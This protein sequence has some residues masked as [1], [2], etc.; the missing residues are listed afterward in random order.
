MTIRIGIM[1]RRGWEISL[2]KV[3]LAGAS[4]ETVKVE[5]TPVKDVSLRHGAFSRCRR[6]AYHLRSVSPACAS[7][8]V[9][10]HE[11]GLTTNVSIG[12][13]GF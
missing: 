7:R 9:T 8:L 5:L 2:P 6:A 11:A 4:T 10:R 12:F 13:G 1:A 3:Q